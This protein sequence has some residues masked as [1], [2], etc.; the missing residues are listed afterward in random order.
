MGENDTRVQDS[1]FV[2]HPKANRRGT[3]GVHD[4]ELL[5]VKAKNDNNLSAPWM[6]NQHHIVSC[7]DKFSSNSICYTATKQHIRKGVE[8]VLGCP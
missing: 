4:L 1:P 5:G 8:G 6:K 7:G 3:T 2:G